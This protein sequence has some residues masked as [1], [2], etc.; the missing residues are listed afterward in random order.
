MCAVVSCT[1]V[2]SCTHFVH[3]LYLL[4]VTCAA[5]C[6]HVELCA[7]TNMKDWC[8]QIAQHRERSA[9]ARTRMYPKNKS[10]STIHSYTHA[11]N[12]T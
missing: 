7:H 10:T 12:Y 3:S 2:A 8:R 4:C 9:R 1:F 11:D 6:S 5:D